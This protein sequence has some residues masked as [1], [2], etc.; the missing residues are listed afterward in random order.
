MSKAF[1]STI[2]VLI[3]SG[4]L[5]G[6][7]SPW[8]QGRDAES[9]LILTRAVCDL[10]LDPP[11]LFLEGRNL[12]QDPKV[13]MGT[14]GGG[15]E[16]LFLLYASDTGVEAL[17]PTRLP[18]TYLVIVTSGPGEDEVFAMNV[19]LSDSAAETGAK[20]P[21][22]DRG[23]RGLPGPQGPPGVKGERGD[24]GP[25]G[26]QGQTGLLSSLPSVGQTKFASPWGTNLGNAVFE[27]GDVG[28]GTPTPQTKLDVRGVVSVGFSNLAQS[29]MIRLPNN[30]EIKARNSTNDGDM[31]IFGTDPNYVL[32]GWNEDVIVGRNGTTVLGETGGKV[33]I[34]T[35]TPS[36]IL[37]V[38]GN[39]QLSGNLTASGD[40]S[41]DAVFFSGDVG[42][43]NTSPGAALHV[44][45]TTGKAAI[46]RTND[47]SSNLIEAFGGTGG[48]NLR[49]LVDNDGKV[50]IDESITIGGADFAESIEVV[51]DSSLYEPGDV[52]V[53]DR[54]VPNAVDLSA[55]PYSTLVAGVYSTQP[56]ILGGRNLDVGDPTPE[57]TI[58]MAVVGIVPCKVSAENGPILPGDLLV[59]SSTSGHAMKGTDP[60]RL[61]GAIVGKALQ[62]L[63]SDRGVIS[64]LVTLQ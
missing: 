30:A 9:R 59:T 7:T 53:I 23:P 18:G 57:N 56:G 1:P 64:V 35:R 43:G 25:P 46:F 10:E 26:A 31:I 14:T 37:E 15:L 3:V 45:A 20:G 61:V 38:D 48:T 2:R 42:V 4:L 17:L 55:T 5:L 62:S 49:F 21:I 36:E 6:L 12:G 39:I 60:L 32:V 27:G 24:P 47:D 44:V 16:E 8:A 54:K 51:S 63:Q 28:I 58:P 50:S 41:A 29:G 34:G 40:L 52:L 11:L 19:T 22:G 13:F 33:G